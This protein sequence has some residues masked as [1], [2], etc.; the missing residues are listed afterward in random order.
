MVAVQANRPVGKRKGKGV[1][2]GGGDAAVL[3]PLK[4]DNPAIV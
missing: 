3:G 4:E 2:P 1:A